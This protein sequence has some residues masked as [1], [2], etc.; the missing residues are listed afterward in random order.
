MSS[1]VPLIA[2]NTVQIASQEPNWTLIGGLIAAFVVIAVFLL[3]PRKPQ[4]QDESKG[5][6]AIEDKSEKKESAKSL[7]D[8]EKLSLAEIKEAKRENVSADKSKEELRELRKERRAAIQTDK[9]IQERESTESTDEKG[10]ALEHAE[11]QDD[12]KQ[13]NSMKSA[14]EETANAT[15]TDDSDKKEEKATC[16]AEN[17]TSASEAD[18]SDEAPASKETDLKMDD[19]V[20]QTS[21]DTG[22]VFA[23][24]FGN[25]DN[26]DLFGNASDS[27]L[28]FDFE[29][30]PATADIKNATV[31]PTLGSALIPLDELRKQAGDESHDSNPLDEL[32]KRLAAKAEKKTLNST[33]TA[34]ES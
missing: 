12:A 1:I 7:E 22:D 31:F 16:N 27:K 9:A 33:K 29:S 25:D 18:S 5:T 2:Q 32:T 17:V 30:K 15:A 6:K 34:D 21:S 20:T 11:N 24:L 23:S 10:A 28:D 4:L 3:I 13:D 8:K 14:T 26:M 19:V